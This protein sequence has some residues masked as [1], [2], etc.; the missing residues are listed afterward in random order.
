MAGP[1]TVD[2]SYLA[3]A[4]AQVQDGNDDAVAVLGLLPGQWVVDVGC[5]AGDGLERLC[6][7]VGDGA[8]VGIDHDTDLLEA[9]RARAP[10]LS[11]RFGTQL[12]FHAADA[13]KLPLDAGSVDAVTCRFVCQHLATPA[14]AV[15]EMH[16]VLRPGGRLSLLDADWSTLSINGGDDDVE[17]V[18]MT[19]NTRTLLRCGAAGRKLPGLLRGA[20]FVDVQRRG[21]AEVDDDLPLVRELAC[22]TE[23]ED[24]ALHQGLLTAEAIARWRQDLVDAADRGAFL[25]LSMAVLAWARVDD[26]KAP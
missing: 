18:L 7:A 23:I 9:A 6:A 17:R 13:A 10:E 14:D 21:Y 8:V 3:T 26:V 24:A 19:I 4:D 1:G 15:A 25:A 2:A 11:E 5:G 22:L 20:G 16:R 12:S